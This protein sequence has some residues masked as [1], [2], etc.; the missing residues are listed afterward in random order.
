MTVLADLCERLV[1]EFGE[2]LVQ[3]PQLLQDALV[4]TLAGEVTVEIRFAAHAEYSI[5]WQFG[6]HT[7]GIDTAPLHPGLASYPNHLHDAHG[8]TRADPLTDPARPPWENVRA[9]LRRVLDD[10]LMQR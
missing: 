10:P 8:V 2:Q 5:R 4:V 6:E 1:D 3:P 7:L 9:V